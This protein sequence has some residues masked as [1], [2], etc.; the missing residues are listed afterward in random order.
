MSYITNPKGSSFGLFK[1]DTDS[2]NITI[3]GQ[4]FDTE[5]G[6]QVVL[7]KAGAVDLVSGVLTQNS[8]LVANHQAL[9]VTSFTAAST[10]NG[11]P[12]TI[13]ATLGA[14]AATAQQYQGGFVT[15]ESGTGIG[16]MLRI[17]SSTAA[18]ASASITIALEDAPAVALDNTSVICLTAA[19]YTGVVI[20]PTTATA[21]PAGVTLY[22]VTAGSYGY[23]VVR[24]ITA[25]LSDATVAAVGL[26]LTASTTTAGCITLGTAT[27][28]RVGIAYQTSIS[29]KARPIFVNL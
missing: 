29:A 28:N 21:S 17:A 19:P 16:Q 20:N 10:S 24:G 22:P 13:V 23:M 9:A 18:S 11:T 4:R 14:T 1:T 26:G 2:S 8:P 25:C 15:V 6:R 3:V 27:G 12:A 5:D 7:F